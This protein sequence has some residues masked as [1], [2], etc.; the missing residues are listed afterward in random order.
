MKKRTQDVNGCVLKKLI[1]NVFFGFLLVILFIYISNVVPFPGLLSAT[2]PS[3][4]PSPLPLK[5]CSLTHPPTP[6]SMFFFLASPHP[7]HC[8]NM[9]LPPQDQAP[10]FPLMPDKAI[11]SLLNM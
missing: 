5:Q 8:S 9:P 10:P 6:T 4:P 3:H 11:S 1:G 2:P 7:L